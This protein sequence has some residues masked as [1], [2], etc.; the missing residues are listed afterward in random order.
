MD[1]THGDTPGAFATFASS[2]FQHPEPLLPD[3]IEVP[4]P[5]VQSLRLKDWETF[6]IKKCKYKKSQSEQHAQRSHD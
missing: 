4:S 2:G 3:N 1:G 5:L 6:H